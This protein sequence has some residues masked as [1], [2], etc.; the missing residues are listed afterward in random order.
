MVRFIGL[1]V[2]VVGVFVVAGI[3]VG[4]TSLA[5][6]LLSLGGE[7][8]GLAVAVVVVPAVILVVAMA[9]VPRFWLGFFAGDIVRL[10]FGQRRR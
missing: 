1:M 6:D 8:F 2:G 4:F 9:L 5:G 7:I 3:L 10:L